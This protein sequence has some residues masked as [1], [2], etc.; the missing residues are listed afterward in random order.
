MMEDRLQSD[1]SQ[2]KELTG[3]RRQ[4]ASV[5]RVTL[6]D[7]AERGLR[8]LVFSTGGGL[9]FWVLSD[10]SMDIGPLSWKGIPVAWQHPAGYAT[11]ASVTPQA[12]ARNDIERALSGF[13]LTCGLDNARQPQNGLPLHGTLPLT[14]ARITSFG[15]DWDAINPVLFAEG[16]VTVAHLSGSSFRLFRRI[17]APIGGNNFTISD[18][19]ENIGPDAAEMKILYHINFGYPVVG[20]GTIVALNGKDICNAISAPAPNVQNAICHDVTDFAHF[21][22]TVTCPKL[23]DRCGLQAT[24]RGDSTELPFVQIWNDPRIRRNILSIEPSNCDR[25]HDGTS[26]SGTRLASG[27]CWSSTKIYTFES[28]CT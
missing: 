8:A 28:I 13:L 17:E 23:G 26:K 2:L 16:E 11:R 25:S 1:F 15:E 7:G 27:E 20:A 14:P 4:F 24:I 6:D 5:R 10:R 19:I 9:D 3:D 12:T 22:A 21:E 18:R